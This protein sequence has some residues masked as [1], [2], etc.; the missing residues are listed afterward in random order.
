MIDNPN[1][2]V[3]VERAG[4]DDESIRADFPVFSAAVVVVKSWYYEGEI[5][6]LGVQILKRGD[7]GVL[8]SEY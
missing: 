7:D 1:P 2:W 5:D 6:E 3:V 4:T 8:T